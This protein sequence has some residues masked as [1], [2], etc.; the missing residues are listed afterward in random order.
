M[1]STSAPAALAASTAS[2]SSF[3]LNEP[4]RMDPLKASNRGFVDTWNLLSTRVYSVG[5]GAAVGK[6]AGDRRVSGARCRELRAGDRRSEGPPAFVGTLGS[7]PRRPE[8]R[9]RRAPDVGG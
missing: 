2:A 8:L 1:T 5:H 6:S 4:L 3:V 9:P 7:G